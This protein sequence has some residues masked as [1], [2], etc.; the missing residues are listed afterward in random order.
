MTHYCALTAEGNQPRFET[1]RVATDP[2]NLEFEFVSATNLPDEAAR[3][4]RHLTVKLIDHSHF[5]ERWTMVENGKET[6]LELK[7][8]RR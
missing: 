5:T 6:I 2:S 8:V 7:Y 1:G 4:M 3:H